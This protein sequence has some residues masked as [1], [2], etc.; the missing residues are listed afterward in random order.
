MKQDTVVHLV[1]DQISFFHQLLAQGIL[2]STTSGTSIHTFL[3]ISMGISPEYIDHRIQTI[4]L[5]GK[6]VDDIK[7]SFLK[8]DSTLAL[9]AAMPGLVGA[10]FRKSGFYSAFRKNISYEQPSTVSLEQAIDFT[11]KLF[12][13]IAKELGPGLFKA[14]IRI[15]GSSFQNFILH[16]K[17]RFMIVCKKQTISGKNIVAEEFISHKW[18]NQTIHLVIKKRK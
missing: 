6:A 14:G 2:A 13:T 17:E 9:S 18:E 3:T 15:N 10:T 4:F 1:A 5:D 11:L 12:N 8:Q 7:N 16:Q